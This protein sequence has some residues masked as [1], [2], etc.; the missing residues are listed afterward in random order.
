MYRKLNHMEEYFFLY[1]SYM[2]ERTEVGR[3]ERERE[4]KQS[5]LYPEYIK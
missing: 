4:G 3:K 1:N 5:I 2:L